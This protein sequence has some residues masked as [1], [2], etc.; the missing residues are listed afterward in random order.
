MRINSSTIGMESARSY[1]ASTTVK[2]RVFVEEYSGKSAFRSGN[3]FGNLVGTTTGENT[4]TEDKDAGNKDSMGSNAFTAT[5]AMMELSKKVDSMRTNIRSNSLNTANNFKQYTIRSILEL[6]FGR[7]DGRF[8]QNLEGTGAQKNSFALQ[9]VEV[10]VLTLK[11]EYF[12][13]ESE[14]TSFSTT[15]KVSTADGREISIQL[16]LVMSRR[17]TRYFSEE[18]QKME[19]STCDP[20]VLNFNG[21]I[22]AL[23]NHKFFFDIDADGNEEQISML[24]SGSGYLALDRNEDQIINDGSELFGTKTGDAFSELSLYDEDKNGWIDE[25]DDIW[26]KLKIWCQNE[27]G[28]FSLYT[29]ADK[30][31]GAICLQNTHTDFSLNDSNNRT[32][33]IIRRTGF[34][35]YEDGQVGTA[36]HLDLVN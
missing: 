10:N 19:V 17:F 27:D 18:I 14:C 25:N 36:Q 21:N 5:D 8:Y 4:G 2:S 16:D 31:V 28:S 34:F 24:G 3:L 23:R 29:L 7:K 32:N 9:E 20:L 15:G 12:Y 33:G 30:G 1:S 11:N 6:L 26:S 22:A 35:L 13:E